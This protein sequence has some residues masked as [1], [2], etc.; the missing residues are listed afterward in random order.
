MRTCRGEAPPPRGSLLRHLPNYSVVMSQRS[1]ESRVPV[2]GISL[3]YRQ[4]AL[5]KTHHVNSERQSTNVD[6]HAHCSFFVND[7]WGRGL[8]KRLLLQRAEAPG[9]AHTLAFSTRWLLPGS[10]VDRQAASQ[11]AWSAVGLT[12]CIWVFV[13]RCRCPP[14]LPSSHFCGTGGKSS[15]SGDKNFLRYQVG[16]PELEPKRPTV[17]PIHSVSVTWCHGGGRNN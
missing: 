3:M 14:S 6:T 2:G 13:A 11:Q 15:S 16:T 17:K 8:R 4:G 12:S 9:E 7:S 5:V 10:E 1:W